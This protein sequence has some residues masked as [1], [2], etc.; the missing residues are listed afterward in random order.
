MSLPTS[1]YSSRS[2]RARARHT[3]PPPLNRSSVDTSLA[4]SSGWRSGTSTIPVASLIRLVVPDARARATKGSMKCEY[5]SGIT[6]SAVQGK[7]LVVGTGMNGCSAHQ[8]D[9]KPSA[10]AVRAMAPTSTRYAGSGTEMPTFMGASWGG[11]SVE[12]DAAVDVERLAGD[13]PRGRR[14]EED[15]E[16]GHVLRGVGAAGGGDRG[17]PAPHLLERQNLVAGAVRPVGLGESGERHARGE[18][19][20][21]ECG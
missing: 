5:A 19:G 17:A 1:W 6:P 11:R 18:G 4:S 2:I 7:R 10:S 12:D 14:G 21:R 9:S 13:V 16:G 8:N 20:A 3:P 15:R